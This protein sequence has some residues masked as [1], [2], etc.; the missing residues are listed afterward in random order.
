MVL[1]S[2]DPGAGWLLTQLGITEM[3]DVVQNASFCIGPSRV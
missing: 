1:A 3:V 2:L